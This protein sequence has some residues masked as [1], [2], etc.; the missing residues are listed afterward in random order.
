MSSSTQSH[1]VHT[2]VTAP[3]RAVPVQGAVEEDPAPVEVAERVRASAH[4]AGGAAGVDLSAAPAPAPSGDATDTGSGL[5][6]LGAGWAADA[7]LF[8]QYRRRGV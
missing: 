5:R 1:A 8:A 4:V 3:L 2:R 7:A 6:F